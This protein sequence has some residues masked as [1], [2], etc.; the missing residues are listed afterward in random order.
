M[1]SKEIDKYLED[2]YYNPKHEASYSSADRLYQFV[3]EDGKFSITKKDIDQFLAR[4]EVYTTHV[5]K[6]KP[7]HFYSVVVPHKKYMLDVD[8]AYFDI[9]PGKHNKKVIVAVDV[10]SRQAKARAVKDLKAKTV[11]KALSSIIDEFGGVER[12]RF[13]RGSEYRN[14]VVLNALKNKK[15]KFFFSYLAHKSNYAEAFIKT[16]KHQLYRAS[17]HRGDADWTTILQDVVHSYNNRKHAGLFGLSP[18]QVTEANTADLWF[19]AKRKRLS[20]MPPHKAFKFDLHENVRI[21][22]SRVPFRKNFMEQNSTIV[23]KITSR[24][25]RAHI[26]RYTVKDQRNVEQPGSF[27]ES[28]LT[29]TTVTDSTEYRIERII[30]YKRINKVRHA[31]VKWLHYPSKYNSYV[32]EADIFNLKNKARA[33]KRRRKT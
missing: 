5:Q 29:A 7:K 16:L 26:N 24:Y 10:F 8:S 11:E 1:L 27:T 28:Q 32:P 3:K 31:L 25:R 22:Y 14:N 15:V 18:N 19:K 20:H 6:K 13:D 23:Y 33:R 2:I 17:Q 4:S 9:G 21:V 30:S 12:V